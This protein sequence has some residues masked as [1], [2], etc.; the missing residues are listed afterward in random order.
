MNTPTQRRSVEQQGST[1]GQLAV[2]PS[3][4]PEL[5]TIAQKEP[6][7]R[8]AEYRCK[9]I[10]HEAGGAPM[11][12]LTQEM[13]RVLNLL[14]QINENFAAVASDCMDWSRRLWVISV[15][16]GGR[17]IYAASLE[18]DSPALE[19]KLRLVRHELEEMKVAA[20]RGLECTA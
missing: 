6:T 15:D 16:E 4:N 2:G 8:L 3:F 20:L 13:N 12:S 17:T 7:Q 9:R 1:L 5:T 18:I 14:L 11:N 19:A 10:A